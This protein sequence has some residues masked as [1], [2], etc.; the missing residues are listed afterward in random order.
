M[1]ETAFLL[2]STLLAFSCIPSTKEETAI[3]LSHET[4]ELPQTIIGNAYSLQKVGHFLIVLDYSTD[5]FFH[6]I[7]LKDQTDKGLYGSKGQGPNDFIH[8]GKLH[9]YSDKQLCCFDSSKGEIK[10]LTIHTDNEKIECSVLCKVKQNQAFEII[11]ID[12]NTLLSNGAF[13][14]SM[15]QLTTLQNEILSS[16]EEYPF[17]DDKEHKLPNQLRAMAY[18]GILAM[19][20]Q[21]KIAYA[22]SN[23]HQIHFYDAKDSRLV[24]TGETIKNYAQYIPDGNTSGYSVINDGNSPKCFTDLAVTNNHVYALYSGRT[25]K[26]HQLSYRE[27]EYL[28]V[29]DWNGEKIKSY[30]LDIPIS[31]F[32]IDEKEKKIYAIANLP[33][34]TLVT[35]TL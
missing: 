7:S 2:I 16:S 24:K 30:H 8:P 5:S 10:L 4:I 25:F 9:Q 21:N 17:K 23:A 22:I 3:P 11:P 29:Y 27:S 19:N 28:F 1:K 35:F 31:C 26:E 33:D 32:C 34:P 15:F 6:L 12:E 14:K 13:E 20:R 18:Q